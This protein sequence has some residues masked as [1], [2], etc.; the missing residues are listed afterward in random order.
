VIIAL[1][2]FPCNKEEKKR[3]TSTLRALFHFLRRNGEEN[4][5]NGRKKLGSTQLDER[6]F[7]RR[8]T[9]PIFLFKH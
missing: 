9:R 6:L 8:R 2:Y 5:N 1:A 4:I 3:V 7:G